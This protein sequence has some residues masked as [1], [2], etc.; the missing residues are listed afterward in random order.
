LV[1]DEAFNRNSQKLTSQEIGPTRT[2]RL[3][4][5][6]APVRS[7]RHRRAGFSGDDLKLSLQDEEFSPLALRVLRQSY[8]EIAIR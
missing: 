4:G 8:H 3:P 2:A 1:T 5:E 6:H 7:V